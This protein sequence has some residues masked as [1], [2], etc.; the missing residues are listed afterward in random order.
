MKC[1]NLDYTLRAATTWIR[2]RGVMSKLLG[3][4][5]R[6]AASAAPVAAL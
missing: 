4:D 5:G 6:G 2:E 3:S 1:A